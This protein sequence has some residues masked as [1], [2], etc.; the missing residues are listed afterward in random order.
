[1]LLFSHSVT[2]DS[3]ASPWTAARQKTVA[4]FFM[5]V[6]QLLLLIVGP[7]WLV[8]EGVNTPEQDSAELEWSWG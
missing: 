8:K 3:L 1:M 2:S 5:F 7:V 4:P 6:E